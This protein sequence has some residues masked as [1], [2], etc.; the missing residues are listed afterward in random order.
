M[1]LETKILIG[2][3][4]GVAAFLIVKWAAG[5][6]STAGGNL[7]NYAG[8]K[9]NPASNTNLIY[10]NMIGSVGR[11]IS[12]DEAWTLGGWIYEVINP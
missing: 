5:S 2:I 9:L 4:A 1:R 10:D 12:G 3:S 7:A 8:E 6:I 11:T